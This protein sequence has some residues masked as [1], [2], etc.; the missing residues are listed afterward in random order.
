MAEQFR[1]TNLSAVPDYEIRQWLTIS[2]AIRVA[3]RVVSLPD[4]C[5]GKSPLPT[6]TALLTS[7]P[8]WRR[9]ALSD[10]GCG[11]AVVRTPLREA[12]TRTEN[13]RRTWDGLCSALA[14]RRN[15]GLGD[16]G[17]GNHFLDAAVSHTDGS[18]CLVVHTGSRTESGLVDHL[19]DKPAQF[20]SEF[21]RIRAW[22]GD[23][24]SA[25]LDI[26]QRHLGR[27]VPLFPGTDRLDRDHNHFEE[28]PDGVLIRKGVQRVQPGQ[29]AIIPSQ[30][31][32]DMVIVKATAAVTSIDNCLPHGTGRTM[33]RSDAKKVVYDF[34]E[35]RAKVYIPE[36][37]DNASLRTEAPCCYRS[38]DEGLSLMT[39][40]ADV[41]ERLT[42]V[43]YIGQL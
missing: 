31:L 37:I 15:K 9:F 40:Y 7:D 4:T 41:V 12:D 34:A 13:F 19:V 2:G 24:R 16:L 35:L 33:S 42:P 39:G 23:N 36:Q 27:F 3:R 21:R 18:I 30:L 43:A 8:S 1:F 29:L 38:L 6:G 20:D 10:V 17:S 11:M 22:A 26:A 5:P 28:L 32:D 14:E 25:V